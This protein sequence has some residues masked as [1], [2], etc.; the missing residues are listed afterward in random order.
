MAIAPLHSDLTN[1]YGEF[2]AAARVSVGRVADWLPAALAHVRNK[3]SLENC[4]R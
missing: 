2:A 3:S 4:F 1:S